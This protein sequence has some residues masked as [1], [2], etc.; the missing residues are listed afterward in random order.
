M[1]AHIVVLGALAALSA[2]APTRDSTPSAAPAR[3]CFSVSLI[4]NFRQ[5]GPGEVYLRV[6]G[7]GIYRVQGAGGCWDLAAANQ[8]ALVPDGAGALGSRVCAGDWARIVIPGST[9]PSAACRV[10]VDRRLTEQEV[11]ALPRGQKP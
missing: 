1:R 8:L 11:A 2:C 7:D 5:G 9:A 4:D 10:Q 3:Q 6:R